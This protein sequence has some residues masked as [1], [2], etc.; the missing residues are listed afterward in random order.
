PYPNKA[1]VTYE[2]SVPGAEQIA[3][4]FAKFDTEA[5]YDFV[6]L[7]DA[8]GVL[9]EKL[10]GKNDDSFS[11]PVKGN[12]LKIVLKSDNSVNKYGFDITKI[13][14]KNAASNP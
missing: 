3:I 12:Y 6:E 7:F 5:N 11:S 13:A 8:N 4:Y 14:Y 10:S 2:V 1:A 9:V